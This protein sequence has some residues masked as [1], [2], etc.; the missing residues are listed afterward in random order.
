MKNDLIKISG[1]VHKHWREAGNVE[2][3][4]E[5]FADPRKPSQAKLWVVN[6]EHRFTRNRD[7]F[8]FTVRLCDEV[9]GSGVPS[10]ERWNK[11]IKTYTE[12]VY[13]RTVLAWAQ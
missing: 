4:V 3:I 5:R 2:F 10:N 11:S 8:A 9:G 7:C 1:E 12:E 13:A 6:G